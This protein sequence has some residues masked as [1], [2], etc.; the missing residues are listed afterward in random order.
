V[1]IAAGGGDAG[2]ALGGG[3]VLALPWQ[4]TRG[5]ALLG[6]FAGDAEHIAG[7]AARTAAAMHSGQLL[8]PV[9]DVRRHVDTPFVGNRA[10]R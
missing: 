7:H 6:F 10:V 1:V 2:Q 9:Q 5:S 3:G 8:R 4:H